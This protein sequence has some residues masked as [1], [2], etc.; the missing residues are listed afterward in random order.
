MYSTHYICLSM[1]V[2]STNVH[3]LIQ[4]SK[5]VC[6]HTYT[7]AHIPR[8]NKKNEE[9]FGQPTY[10]VIWVAGIDLTWL[11]GA[12]WDSGLHVWGP[13]PQE[14]G[15]NRSGARFPAPSLSP[16]HVTCPA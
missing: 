12:T 13:I 7:P 1:Y 3:V 5:Y 8:K 6:V 2:M 9:A 15:R 10:P 11:W 16:K 4:C 14:R